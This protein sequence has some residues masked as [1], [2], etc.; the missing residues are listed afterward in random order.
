MEEKK[1][2][3]QEATRPETSERVTLA[4][5]ETSEDF[6]T[7]SFFGYRQAVQDILVIVGVTIIIALIVD[8]IINHQ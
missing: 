5:S 3:E 2:S 7:G 1:Q 4:I 6:L 8:Q